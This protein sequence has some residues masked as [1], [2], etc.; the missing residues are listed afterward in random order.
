MAEQYKDKNNF[1]EKDGRKVPVPIVTIYILGHPCCDKQEPVIYG[2]PEFYNAEHQK[3]EDLFDSDFVNGLIHHLIIVQV[4]F[5]KLNAKTKVE[6]YLDFLNQLHKI[7][8]TKKTS[9]LLRVD[10]ENIDEDYHLIVRRLEQACADEEVRKTM[11][12]EDELNEDIESWNATEMKLREQ[13]QEKDSQLQEKDSQL[14]GKD[15]QIISSIKMMNSFGVPV[16][17]IAE[18]F[19]MDVDEVKQIIT[20]E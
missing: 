6:K 16:E 9:H 19:K 20:T 14:Q 17:K 10:D 2:N 15:A 1:L 7:D 8:K 12:V 3:L 11:E 18:N 5:L 13:I 4:P